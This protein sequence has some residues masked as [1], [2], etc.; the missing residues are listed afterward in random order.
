M[1]QAQRTAYD[2]LT[3]NELIA[4]LIQHDPLSKDARKQTAPYVRLRKNQLIELLIDHDHKDS[5][6]CG[7]SLDSDAK[8][9]DDGEAVSQG[10]GRRFQSLP[11]EVRNEFYKIIAN[12]QIEMTDSRASVA[13]PAAKT[14]EQK[15]D[16]ELYPKDNPHMIILQPGLFLTCKQI[17]VEG[18]PFF[19]QQRKFNFSMDNQPPNRHRH[20][21]GT[22]GLTKWFQ[23]IGHFGQ[24]NIRILDFYN[25]P[26]PKNFKYQERVHRKLSEEA[27]V[28]Y[29]ADDV[30]Y[31]RELWEIASK[32][33]AKNPD[34]VPVVW[35]PEGISNFADLGL[36][37]DGRR[38]EPWYLTFEPGSN[39]F[40]MAHDDK[41]QVW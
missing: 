2:K 4:L 8:R 19:Y 32:Y 18:L 25:G 1:P 14:W 27:T 7:N 33:H 30:E 5:S 37:P 38:M 9:V 35:T 26:T 29:M 6:G 23:A 24:R 20:E 17:R 12:Y 36:R 11:G 22:L 15:E 41:A 28:T 40:G 39:W 16:H 3:K 10:A 34:K 21:I 13:F 31:A